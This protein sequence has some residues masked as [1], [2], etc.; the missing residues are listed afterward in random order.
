MVE[1]GDEPYCVQL[2][3]TIL[4]P[5]ETAVKPLQ[6]ALFFAFGILLNVEALFL[7]FF[8]LA[9]EKGVVFHT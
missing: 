5:A 3:S 2:S 1:G 6:P 7:L 4:T 9:G 8:V